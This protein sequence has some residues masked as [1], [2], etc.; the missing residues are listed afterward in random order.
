MRRFELIIT[1]NDYDKPR[2]FSGKNVVCSTIFDSLQII[3]LII[4]PLMVH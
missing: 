1:L 2:Q 3:S 4:E